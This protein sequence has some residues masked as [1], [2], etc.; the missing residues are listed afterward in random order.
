MAADE[1]DIPFAPHEL[2]APEAALGYLDG[3]QRHR[4]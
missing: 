2:W 3:N 4:T 1:P